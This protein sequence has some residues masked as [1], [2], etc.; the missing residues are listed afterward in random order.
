ML[1]SKEWTDLVT[2]GVLRMK[3]LWSKFEILILG[4]RK[5]G[6]LEVSLV[7]ERR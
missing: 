4:D 2:D 1:Q 3:R 5:N 6:N 7:L